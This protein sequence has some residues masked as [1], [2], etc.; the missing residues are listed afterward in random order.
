MLSTTHCTSLPLL[1]L[2]FR[3]DEAG[4]YLALL[5]LFSRP[6]PLSLKVSS[7]LFLIVY[8]IAFIMV[9][10]DVL[11]EFARAIFDVSIPYAPW[12]LTKSLYLFSIIVLVVTLVG[13]IALPKLIRGHQFGYGRERLVTPI[14]V[15]ITTEDLPKSSKNAQINRYGLWAALKSMTAGQGSLGVLKLRLLHSW[16]YQYDPAI[17][18][19]IEWIQQTASSVRK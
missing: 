13:A 17:D 15:N 18:D 11:A 5:S 8:L 2:R 19:I 12:V 4:V 14:L 6:F 10:A 9:F 7:Y 3:G 16:L 1:A